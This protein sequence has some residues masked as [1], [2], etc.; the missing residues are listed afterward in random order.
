MSALLSRLVRFAVRRIVH[1]PRTRTT[2]ANAARGMAEEARVIAAEKDRAR[3]AGRSVR[4]AMSKL[5]GGRHE[6]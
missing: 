2:V 3:A 5:Q 6:T 1:D 4:R